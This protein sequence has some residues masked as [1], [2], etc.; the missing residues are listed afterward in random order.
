MIKLLS[1]DFY[2][3]KKDK[4]IWI[5]AAAMFV[6]Q[7]F[8]LIDRVKFNNLN[9]TE[10]LL[11]LNDFFFEYMPLT[12]F[13]YAV[14]TALFVGREYSEGT[15]RNKLIMGHKR[16]SI[17]LSCFI[18]C[19]FGSLLIYLMLVIGGL[20]GIPFLGKWQG[21]ADNFIL[22]ILIGIFI[23]AS[24]ASILTAFAML[25]SNRAV[26][27]V[28]SIVMIL[29]FMIAASSI[30][31]MLNEPEFINDFIEITEEGGIQY[32]PEIPNPAYV[33]GAERKID[34]FL[35]QFLP[36]GQ[37]ILMANGEI[38][39]PLLNIACSVIITAVINIVG[40]V[41]FKKKDLK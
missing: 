11:T 2:R 27:A 25:L 6:L 7:L 9:S 31:N 13:L 3:L 18:T 22:Y 40:I 41:A 15:I 4:T 17:Y 19:L 38:S 16:Q 21:G 37:G 35:V 8:M 24:L 34:E 33:T 12:G 36:A 28:L 23:T 39:M 30:Y 26:N 32:G 1:A 10:N 5:T 14:F 20:I 29:F